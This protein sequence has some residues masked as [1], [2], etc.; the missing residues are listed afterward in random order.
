MKTLDLTETRG[1]VAD[2]FTRLNRCDNGEGMGCATLEESL[3][4]YASECDWFCE[5][6]RQQ[7]GSL[8]VG[9]TEAGLKSA[10]LWIDEG[11]S[12]H[13]RAKNRLAVGTTMINVCYP[14]SGEAKL[15]AALTRLEEVLDSCATALDFSRVPG[16]ATSCPES[17]LTGYDRETESG[18][19]SEYWWTPKNAVILQAWKDYSEEAHADS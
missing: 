2:I 18:E 19:P 16:E 3:S 9:S 14:F 4:L 8:L 12:L 13:V 5:T 7:L 17:E 10:R 6:V 15:G 1:Y 11:R